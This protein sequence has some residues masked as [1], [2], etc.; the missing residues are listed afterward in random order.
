M[1]SGNLNELVTATNGKILSSIKTEFAGIGTD[2]RKDLSNQIFWVLK[3]ENFDAHNFLLQAVDKGAVA[4]VVESLPDNSKQLLQQVS[5]L[6]VKDV[7]RALQDY[8]HFMRKKSRAKVIGITGSNGK[9]SC[10]EFTHAILNDYRRVHSNKGSF[11]NHFGLPMNLLAASED[12]EIILAEM[13]M[14]HYHEI[15]RLCEIAEPDIVVCTMVGRAHIEHFGSIDNI[16]KAKREI[17]DFAPASATRIF[18]LDNP[19]TQKMFEQNQNKQSQILRFSNKANINSD[20]NL[21]VVDMSLHSLTIQGHIA[22][23]ESKVTVPVFGEQNIV[24]LSAAAAISLAA[25]LNPD[26]IWQGLKN[27]KTAWGRNQ[28]IQTKSGAEILFDAY[29]ANPD[30]MSALLKN[31]KHQGFSKRRKFAVLAEML[32]LGSFAEKEHYE[33]GRAVAEAGFEGVYFYGL[34]FEHFQRGMLDHGFQKNLKVSA[35]YEES[36]ATEVVNML[37]Q[38][39]L[40]LVKGSRG[41]KLERFVRLASPLRFEEKV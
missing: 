9:T 19:W 30:S 15:Q 18:N 27:C 1:R 34:S 35:V 28:L 4:L 7:L 40:V 5:I 6:Q 20:V 25:G 14:N 32:E 11:N 16:A 29:N 13:G 2:T 8:A 41:M 39:D 22:G 33:L 36:L 26:Q 21:R 17:Y 24:N 10:K 12:S 31:L 38:E 37:S 23:V 3:G